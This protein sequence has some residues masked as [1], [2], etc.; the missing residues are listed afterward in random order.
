[1]SSLSNTDPIKELQAYSQ[2]EI[3]SIQLIVTYIM[4]KKD[5]FL[6]PN[7]LEP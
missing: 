6:K 7:E 3:Q 1:M 4:E 2:V 5:D